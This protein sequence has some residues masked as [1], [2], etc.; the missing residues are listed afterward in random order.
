MSRR[1]ARRFAVLAVAAAALAEPGARAQTI[2]ELRDINGI[3]AHPNAISIDG[4]TVVGYTQPPFSTGNHAFRWTSATGVVPPL[5]TSFLSAA[6]GD[7]GPNRTLRSVGR[8]R[9]WERG[10][11]HHHRVLRS[12]GRPMGRRGNRVFQSLP[13]KHLHEGAR[14]ERRWPDSRGNLPVLPWQQRLDYT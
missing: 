5:D 11:G 14:G 6:N 7:P 4:S 2:S 9:G 8:E 13:G 3:P 10:G 12:A 1:N